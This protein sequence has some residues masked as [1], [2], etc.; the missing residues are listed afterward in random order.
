MALAGMVLPFLPLLPIQVL[1]LNLIYDFAQ[2]GLPLDNVDPEAI[3]QPINW[4][5]SL[6]IAMMLAWPFDHDVTG[7]DPFKPIRQA[8]YVAHD[9]LA[10][11]VN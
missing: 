3:E 11:R 4:D 5:C 8:C 1:L 2:T 10:H 7:G 9:L 6:H